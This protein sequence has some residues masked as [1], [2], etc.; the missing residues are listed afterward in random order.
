MRSARGWRLFAVLLTLTLLG[1]STLAG[2]ASGASQG[3]GTFTLVAIVDTEFEPIDRGFTWTDR[4]ETTDGVAVDGWDGGRCMSLVADTEVANRYMC[5]MVVQLPEGD[6]VT[7]GAFDLGAGEDIVFAV[8]GGSGSFRNVRGEVE[9]K[10]VPDTDD[11]AF[12]IFRLR[13]A[14]VRY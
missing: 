1:T 6:I 9:V 7:A 13:G 3:S 5:E 4:L 2:V 10:P 12:V 8:T 11:R 14:S